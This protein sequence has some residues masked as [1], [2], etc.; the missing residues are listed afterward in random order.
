[1]ISNVLL[2]HKL[3]GFIFAIYILADRIYIRKYISKVNREKFYNFSKKP[4]LTVAMFLVLSGSFL[5]FYIDLN[6]FIILKIF[7]AFSLF[8]MFFNCPNYMKKQKDEKNKMVYR[9]FVES[10]LVL[11]ILTIFIASTK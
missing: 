8:V 7:F 4:L 6:F 2:F 1:M 5:L 11:I 10:L 9:F 3:F